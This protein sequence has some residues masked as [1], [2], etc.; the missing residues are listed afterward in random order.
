MAND[1]RLSIVPDT[2]QTTWEKILY[3]MSSP[4]TLLFSQYLNL[5]SNSKRGLHCDIYTSSKP[6]NIY[7]VLGVQIICYSFKA[8]NLFFFFFLSESCTYSRAETEVLKPFHFNK[9][10]HFQ[11]GRTCVLFQIF[12]LYTNFQ[13]LKSFI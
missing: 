7:S 8:I 5:S 12:K 2:T 10:D 11:K 3:F 13:I 6:R 1:P 4:Q 9:M